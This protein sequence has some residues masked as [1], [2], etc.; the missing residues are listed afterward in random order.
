MLLLW[1]NV[2]KAVEFLLQGKK[3]IFLVRGELFQAFEVFHSEEQT[4]V[5]DI[6]KLRMIF[7]AP[8]SFHSLSL[9]VRDAV[10][11]GFLLQVFQLS[12]LLYVQLRG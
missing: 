4:S 8:K 3:R 6:Q 1:S 7:H 2:R 9:E 5:F 12:F 10:C 11:T